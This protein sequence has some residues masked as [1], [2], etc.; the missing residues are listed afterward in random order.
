[1]SS[2][3]TSRKT[4]V[5]AVKASASN[6]IKKDSVVVPSKSAKNVAE[7]ATGLTDTEIRKRLENAIQVAGSQAAFAKLFGVSRAYISMVA[8]GTKR[9]PDYILEH[10]GLT[11]IEVVK[12][13]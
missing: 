10:L 9:V 5:P 6:G 13:K 8:S 11:R 1:M 4:V 3:S 7:A 2:S 12:E